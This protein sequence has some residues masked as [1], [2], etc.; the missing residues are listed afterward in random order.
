MKRNQKGITLVALVVTIIVL[1]ILAGVSLNLVSGSNGILTRATT[2]AQKNEIGRAKEQAELYLAELTTEYYETK[3]VNGT[4]G[5]TT[6]QDYVNGKSTTRGG[7]VITCSST[8]ITV[9]NAATGGSLSSTLSGTFIDDTV[10][11]SWNS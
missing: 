4:A 11:I 5:T 7:F 9:A 8:G 2:S 1:L 3:Y 10:A 6:I